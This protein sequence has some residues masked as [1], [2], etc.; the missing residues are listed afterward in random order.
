MK[1]RQS[2]LQTSPPCPK[3]DGNGVFLADCPQL[4]EYHGQPVLCDC[5]A[6]LKL[7]RERAAKLR[8]ISQLPPRM[9]AYTFESYAAL[10][11]SDTQRRAVEIAATYARSGSL[12]ERHGLFLFGPVGTGKS[13][14]AAA[15]SNAA[16][17]AGISTIYKTAPDLMDY[18][19]SSFKADN[20]VSYD[21]ILDQ[22]QRVELLV[23][24]DLGTENLTAWVV[25]KL[26]QI[27]DFRYRH[28]MRLIVTSNCAPDVLMERFE[29]AGEQTGQRIVDR[30]M[31]MCAL[32]EV[33]GGNLRG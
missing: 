33:S 31:E 14:L 23:L 13:G 12:G 21:K 28:D 16:M 18:I 15:I 2:S 9:A 20:D 11:L 1:S 7:R 17:N 30:I 10:R 25:E 6:G 19:R 26:F 5:A 27:V 29:R 24:D 22:I 3:C 8:A 4:P 32:V